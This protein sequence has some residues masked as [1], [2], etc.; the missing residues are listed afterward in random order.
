MTLCASA[1][2]DLRVVSRQKAAEAM[3]VH[4]DTVNTMLRK[5]EL[6][7]AKVKGK[8]RVY[9]W[10]I[11]LYLKKHEIKPDQEKAIERQQRRE[12]RSAGHNAAL[13]SLRSMG[14]C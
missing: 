5:G 13:K 2:D 12:T 10:S 11:D 1:I 4:P 3:D 9:V 7:G 6:R 8:I 14:I